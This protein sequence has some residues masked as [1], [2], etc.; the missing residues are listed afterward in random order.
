MAAG[1]GRFQVVCPSSRSMCVKQ[2]T[3]AE[4]VLMYGYWAD[5]SLECDWDGWQVLFGCGLEC[6]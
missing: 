4:A 2:K 1:W 6:L 5:A 3:D